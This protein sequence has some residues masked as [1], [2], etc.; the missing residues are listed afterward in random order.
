[1]CGIQQE[2]WYK[3]I[4][5]LMVSKQTKCSPMVSDHQ[6]KFFQFWYVFPHRSEIVCIAPHFAS[7]GPR[8]EVL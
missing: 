3:N 4:T 5:N 7:T 2:V 8:E 1:M 6:K